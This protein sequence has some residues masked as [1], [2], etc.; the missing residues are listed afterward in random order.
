MLK[1]RFFLIVIFFPLCF[2]TIL[3]TVSVYSKLMVLIVRD[4]MDYARCLNTNHSSG[5]C[6]P[7]NQRYRSV[8]VAI[9]DLVMLDVFSVVLVAYMLV[10]PAARSFW[11]RIFACLFQ[12]V[13]RGRGTREHVKLENMTVEEQVSR[14][15]REERSE[16]M[17]DLNSGDLE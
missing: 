11:A 7:T 9:I 1:R 16:S 14:D 17:S 5:D 3:T 2:C 15:E 12:C 6:P 10:P 8:T 4:Y 13:C